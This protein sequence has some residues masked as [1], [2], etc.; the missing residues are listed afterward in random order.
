MD[1]EEDE[2]TTMRHQFMSERHT[3][4]SNLEEI[5]CTDYPV[6]VNVSKSKVAPLKTI[7]LPRLEL[8]GAALL[9][10]LLKSVCETLTLPVSEIYLW[11]DSTIT[12]AWLS[13]PPFHWKTFVANKVSEIL[14]NVGNVTW[15][16]VPTADNPA[17]IGTRGTTA[18]ELNSNN[19]WWHG[20]NWLTQPLEFWPKQTSLKELSLERKVNTNHTTL[21]SEEILERFSSLDRALRVISFMFRFVRK[22]QKRLTPQ[23][24]TRFIT[25]AE[26]NYVKIQLIMIA[27][28]TYY[29]PEYS[30][31]Q[32]RNPISLKSRLLTLNPFLDE[33]Q[34]LRVNG[35]LANADISYNERHPI[36]LP[37]KSRF[38]KLFIDF[39]HKITLHAEH[40]I[41]LRAIRQEFYVIRLKNSVRHCI[42]NC[43]TCTIYKNRVKHQIMAA[44]PLERCTFSLP[45]TNTGVDFA[46][47]FDLK[48]S[49]LRNAK[50]QKGYATVF[51]CLSTRT[52]H[53]ETCS[54]LSSEAFLATFSR[55][56]G[57][58]GFPNKIFSDNGTN[59]VGGSRILKQEY[60][61]F[62][63]SAERL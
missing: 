57:R 8:C 12:L 43:R 11:S 10:R 22:C 52:I 38:C 15:R 5:V 48:T 45:F 42:R 4:I 3:K 19:L 61:C 46:G 27:Q 49:C 62:L 16:H 47:P 50:I 51:V 53:L 26:I 35:R 60:K 25:A 13:K 2:E 6:L 36:I 29:F 56:V 59:F 28:K 31:L 23:M 37:E 34:F 1:K 20:P 40:Q 14:D 32:S 54:D 30:A 24:E 33:N 7:N 21:Q 41:M 44:L 63:R 18:S 58:R 39:T 9:S 55:F 17:D